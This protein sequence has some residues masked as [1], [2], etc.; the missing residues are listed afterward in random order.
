MMKKTMAMLL[1]AVMMFSLCACGNGAGETTAPQNSNETT[2]PVVTPPQPSETEP[3]AA[4]VDYTIKVVDEGGNPVAGVRVQICDVTGSCRLPKTTNE[5]GI[6][7]Y[8][9][10]VEDTYKAQISG[11]EAGLPEGYTVDDPA[12]YYPMGDNNEVTIVLKAIQ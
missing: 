10:E 7:V 1:L 9:D 11:G 4:G 8:E 2:A 6:A 5:E 3:E 12:A